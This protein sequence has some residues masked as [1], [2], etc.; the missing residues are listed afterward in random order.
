M[1]YPIIIT[2]F[3]GFMIHP[4]K[5]FT[6]YFLLIKFRHVLHNSWYKLFHHTKKSIMSIRKRQRKKKGEILFM[7]ETDSVLGYG[8]YGS[9]YSLR[10]A[11]TK[12]PLQRILKISPIHDQRRIV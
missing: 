10:D 8:T 3:W 6:A 4:L 12:Q 5:K 11:R 7:M 9:V 2:G 1:P